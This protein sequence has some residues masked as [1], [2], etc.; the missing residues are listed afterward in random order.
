MS[1]DTIDRLNAALSGRYRLDR[2]LG[3]GGMA[4]VYLAHDERHDRPVAVKVLKPELAAVMGA[5][6]FLTEI[7]TTANLQHPH[8]L[9]L[10]DS[11]EADGFLYY[12]MPYVEGETLRDLLDRERQLPVDDAVRIAR[13]V[14]SALD[15]AHRQ[16]VIHR[17]IKPA[18]ILLHDGEPVVADFGIALAVQQAGG[19]RLTETGLSLGTPY[20]MSPEQ[21]TA[22]R[23]PGPRSDVY[24]LGCVLYEMLAGEPPFQGGTAQAVL[25]RILTGDVPSV[26]EVRKTVPRHVEATLT[27]ALQRLPADRF[28]TAAEFG[29][30]LARPGLTS[31]ASRAPDAAARRRI[32]LLPW[33]V[34]AAALVVAAV[35][36][37]TPG[38]LALLPAPVTRSVL[39]LPEGAYLDNLNP[40]ISD[41][42]R[43]IIVEAWREGRTE[44]LR[45]PLD[46]LAFESVPASVGAQ[47]PVLSPDGASLVYTIESNMVARPL[48][49]GPPLVL[50]DRGQQAPSDWADDGYLYYTQ[51]YRDGVSRVPEG[52]GAP[53]LLS[54]PDDARGELAHWWPQL[55]PGGEHVLFTVF[56]TPVDSAEIAV[57][58]L[59]S[60]EITR[61]FAGG[62]TGR[63]VSTGH[64]LYARN[65]ALFA[66]PFDLASLSLTGA[67]SVVVEDL[68]IDHVNGRGA[69]ALSENGTLVYIAASD[70][71]AERDLLYPPDYRRRSR[72]RA[73]LY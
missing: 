33:S 11:G 44:L 53:E 46:A 67:P 8:I 28:A 64:I 70:F 62:V 20:Y 15:Y 58:D 36:W 54:R 66:V 29:E 35:S 2:E 9:A 5:D 37:M 68:A 6:R 1:A 23:D 49:G 42:G 30:A 12:V 22:D 16:N 14:A 25:G 43:Q 17:D 7:R 52:G 26:T 48:S 71:Y 60:R 55:L 50:T 32:A 69:F 24:S 57:L 4:T 73:L 61:L 39:E 45:R 38:D 63:Y 72:L 31:G 40:M 56:R 34:A 41:D 13:A 10:F 3:A 18:N 59:E 21:A 27:K 19:G 65:D 47:E 51:H